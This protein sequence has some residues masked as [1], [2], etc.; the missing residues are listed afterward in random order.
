MAPPYPVNTDLLSILGREADKGESVLSAEDVRAASRFAAHWPGEARA[1]A[2]A[3]RATAEAA[4]AQLYDLIGERAPEIVW[5][6]SPAD[7]RRFTEP[8]RDED[9]GAPLVPEAAR[10]IDGRTSLLRALAGEVT[11]WRH[12]HRHRHRE[13]TF[14]E[15]FLPTPT[16]RVEAELRR[17]WPRRLAL[18]A[19]LVASC[20]GW[21]PYASVCV[22]S[23]R[24]VEVHAEP[25]PERGGGAVRLHRA[26]GPAMRYRDGFTLYALNGCLLPEHVA[27]SARSGTPPPPGHRTDHRSVMGDG[28]GRPGL[29][30]A[31]LRGVAFD[32]G[33]DLAGADLSGADLRWTDLSG[34]L[35]RGA[36]LSGADLTGAFIG[37]DQCLDAADLT[38]VSL[39]GRDLA[40]FMP[41]LDPV[42]FKGAT[43]IGTDFTGAELELRNSGEFFAGALWDGTTRW[44]AGAA[45]EIRSFSSPCEGGYRVRD[46]QPRGY[47]PPAALTG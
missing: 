11:P 30:G 37:T 43:L 27:M 17:I 26:D 3:D 45:E 18:W 19:D 46:D 15:V 32:E 13:P 36:N 7:E 31:D 14:R 44:P 8:V 25:A 16:R 5:V 24:P 41:A 9:F 21:W 35:L 20:G 42:S 39:A 28:A 29:R 4:I 23:E 40:G 6:G 22:V 47:W 33:T 10:K 1:T 12:R 2:P 34:A 38:G